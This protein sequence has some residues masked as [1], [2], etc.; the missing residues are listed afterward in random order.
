MATL[1]NSKVLMWTPSI[2]KAFQSL[3]ETLSSAPIL[4]LSDFSKPFMVTTD[5]SGQAIG[6]VLTQE[7]KPIDFESKKLRDHE[8]NYPTHNLE[9]LAIVHALKI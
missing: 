2:E 6:G 4:A 1:K 7:G 5:A 9:L 3:K 8:L